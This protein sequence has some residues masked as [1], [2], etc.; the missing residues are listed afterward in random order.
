MKL[1]L[2]LGDGGPVRISQTV[3]EGDEIAGFRVLHLPGHTPGMIALWRESDRL[4]IVSDCFYTMDTQTGK[5]CSPRVPH[6][7]FNHDTDGARTAMRKLAAMR[8]SAAWPGHADPI[9]ENV[10]AELERAAS[11]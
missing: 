2:R 6:C 3:S 9:L 5:K 1:T 7:S 4:A 10:A 11:E 8:P